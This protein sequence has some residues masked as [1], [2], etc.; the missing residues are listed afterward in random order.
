MLFIVACGQTPM[1][2]DG[3][4]TQNEEVSVANEDVGESL[5]PDQSVYPMTIVDSL[6]REVTIEKEPTHII[7]VA[8]NITETI[9]ALGLGDRLIGRTDYCS[10]PEEASIVQSVGLLTD[11]NLEVIANLE[12]DLIVAS[13]HFKQDVLDNL[14]SLGYTVVVLYG[15][16]S[17]EG[18][19]DTIDALGK[20]LNAQEK[21]LAIQTAMQAKVA[22]VIEKV[23]DTEKPSVYYVVAYGES[24]DYTATGETFIAQIIEMAGGDNVAKDG[25]GWRFSHEKLVERDPEM[26]IC[27]EAQE[28]KA[29]IMSSENYQ[30]LTAVKEGRVFEIDNNLL[31]R[32][33][34][35][36]ADGLE[37]VA[38]ILHPEAF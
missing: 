30:L 10:Y 35:R 20:I 8:P 6:G 12:P 28:G 32:Q 4:A 7:S 36:L 3:A 16:S 34:P 22:D 23:K 25:S 21:S 5:T 2:D 9:F 13:T 24:G 15:E 14:E 17:F 37:A 27:S 33:G 1:K 19:Y 18:V 26:I 31:D 11:P 29:G 38:K